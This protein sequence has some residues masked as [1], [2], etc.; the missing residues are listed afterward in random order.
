VFRIG[1]F[2]RL[3]RVSCRL[4]RHYD[5]LGL[6]K[7]AIVDRE[8]G[9]RLYSAAQ[10]P[11][12]N[13]I[14]VLKELGLSLEQIGRVLDDKASAA[15]LR[16]MLLIRRADV[17]QTLAAESDRLRQ[18]EAR[19]SLIDMEGHLCV[20]DVLVRNEPARRILTLR[21]SVR[22]FAEARGIIGQ[23]VESVPRQVPRMILGSLIAI[24]HSDEFEPD[25]LDVEIG[26]ILNGDS[27]QRVPSVAGVVMQMRE[28]PCVEH[29]A[30]CVRVGL[31]E[32]AHLITAKVAQFV[33]ANGYSLAGPSR[34]VFVKAPDVERMQSSVVEMQYP[35]EKRVRPVQPRVATD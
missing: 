28:L 21:K 6:L 24:A 1:D 8:N 13:R 15:E 4:L 11:R 14:L 27:I 10:L 31:P 32:Q 29:L 9:Y 20:D 17:E 5:E 16:A 30:V 2:S 7:P 18:I 25:A 35:I 3:A 34:E 33:E 23:L 22:S 26:Y 19:I 12:L